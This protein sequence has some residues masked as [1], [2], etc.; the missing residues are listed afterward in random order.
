MIIG[1]ID[2]NE[3]AHSVRIHPS[4]KK[5]E[6]SLCCWCERTAGGQRNDWI[7]MALTALLLPALCWLLIE[8]LL[9]K[10]GNDLYE[11]INESTNGESL[12][13]LVIFWV[14][15]VKIKLC[16]LICGVRVDSLKRMWDCGGG[17]NCNITKILNGWT[18]IILCLI[19]IKVMQLRYSIAIE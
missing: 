2:S 17:G 3:A 6:M 5:M 16:T 19:E 9:Y 13:G 14:D 7:L 4:W 10:W 12:F 18:Y 11:R 15:A 8:W 1:Y